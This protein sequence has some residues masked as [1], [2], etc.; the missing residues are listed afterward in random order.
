MNFSAVKAFG[1]LKPQGFRLKGNK[2]GAFEYISDLG[3]RA[4]LGAVS[5]NKV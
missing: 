1:F 2:G 4:E 3:K 5:K